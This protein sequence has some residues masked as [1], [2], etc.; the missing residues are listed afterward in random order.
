M[1]PTSI[2]KKRDST[3]E[4]DHSASAILLNST[5]SR[6]PWLTQPAL[7]AARVVPLYQ[8]PADPV[9]GF[10]KALPQGWARRSWELGR[11]DGCRRRAPG[12]SCR[13][14]RYR[15]QCHLG[16]CGATRPRG[17]PVGVPLTLLE[18]RPRVCCVFK[19][20]FVSYIIRGPA[21]YLCGPLVV[22]HSQT[23]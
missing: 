18:R 17:V 6:S 12:R 7:R 23:V 1:A 14:E 20:G 15:V 3:R 16:V 8:R 10:S 9:Q 11:Q 4:D 13:T 22:W 19:A 21:S 2:S 5:P